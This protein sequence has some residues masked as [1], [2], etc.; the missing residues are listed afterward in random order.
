MAEYWDLYDLHGNL[1]D[2]KYIR[3]SDAPFPQNRY[4]IVVEIYTVWQGKL[5]LTKRDERKPFGGLWEYTG[6]S[7][8]AGEDSRTGAARELEEETGIVR[9]P[10]E[11]IPL[12]SFLRVAGRGRHLWRMDAYLLILPE[13]EPCPKVV[14]QEGETVDHLWLKRDVAGAF[15]D[16]PAFVGHVARRYHIVEDSLWNLVEMRK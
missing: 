12:S 4:H 3:D 8:T 6:G 13:D 11:F 7:V 2:E 14:Y 16:S 1:T 5:L 15:I 9:D 10:S